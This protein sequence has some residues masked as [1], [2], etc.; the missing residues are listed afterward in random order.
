MELKEYKQTVEDLEPKVER[1]KALYSQYF[2]GIEKIPLATD[3][4]QEAPAP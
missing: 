2:M 1:L 3:Q 4:L